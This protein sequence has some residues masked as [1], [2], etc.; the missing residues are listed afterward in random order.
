MAQFLLS[1]DR[2]SILRPMRVCL[3]RLEKSR[4]Q[5]KVLCFKNPQSRQFF[6][7]CFFREPGRPV[8]GTCYYILREP[9]VVMFS[10]PNLHRVHEAQ[11]SK[12]LQGERGLTYP[13]LVRTGDQLSNFPKFLVL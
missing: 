4:E 9:T 12:V 11:I 5:T 7:V 8:T 2:Q 3:L 10:K 13:Q 6:A 1:T